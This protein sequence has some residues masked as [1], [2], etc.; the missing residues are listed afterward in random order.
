M[1]A[2]IVTLL[3]KSKTM[4]DNFEDLIAQL[5]EFETF[6]IKKLNFCCETPQWRLV[7]YR[8]KIKNYNDNKS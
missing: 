1:N 5:L 4:K 6:R 7:K 3:D 8:N 2:I